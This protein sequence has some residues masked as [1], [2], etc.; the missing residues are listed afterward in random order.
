MS[1]ITLENISSF[2]KHL[3]GKK[4]IET[5]EKC[6]KH[7]DKFYELFPNNPELLS[8]LKEGDVY[9]PKSAEKDY[10]FNYIEHRLKPLGHITVRSSRPYKNAI[11]DIGFFRKLLIQV[12]DKSLPVSK[13]LSGWEKIKFF[14]GDKLIAKKIAFL[15]DKDNIYPIYKNSDWEEFFRQ[16]EIGFMEESERHF[17]RQYKDLLIEEKFEIFNS[18]LK[19]F[20]QNEPLI[21]NWET[22]MV[23]GLLYH[24]FKISRIK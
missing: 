11:Q 23:G 20:Q 17:H 9:N 13:R 19:R 4:E 22:H 24:T 12:T 1:K 2:R 6:L 3:Q 21:K 14:G 10:F 18:L 5:S 15:Y 16:L 8:L 7:L